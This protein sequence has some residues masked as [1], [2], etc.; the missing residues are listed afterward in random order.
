MK[1]VGPE[2]ELG[3][4]KDEISAGFKIEAVTF[5]GYIFI[6]IPDLPKNIMLLVRWLDLVRY[7]CKSQT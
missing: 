2:G 6:R 1:R 4:R 3:N 5:F 7:L